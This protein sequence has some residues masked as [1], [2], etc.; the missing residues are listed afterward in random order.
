MARTTSPDGLARLRAFE[1]LRLIPYIDAV[2]IRSV[3][4]G[5][6]RWTGG[7]ITDDQ[8]EA[9][10]VADLRPCEASV[11]QR[12]NVPI[13]QP[14]FDALV[15]LVFNVGPGAIIGTELIEDL[16]AGNYGEAADHILDFCHGIVNGVKVVLPVLEARRTAERAM[17]LSQLPDEPDAWPPQP[18][19][20]RRRGE[21]AGRMS[22]AA[23]HLG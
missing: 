10:L 21:R 22:R 23:S 20:S 13:T 14:Q 8:A 19:P 6:S 3:G 18:W 12:V 17:F 11:N 1:G 9:L 15:S 16:N 5:H 4:Y 7:T 2:G